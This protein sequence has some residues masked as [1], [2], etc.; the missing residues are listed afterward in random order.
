MDRVKGGHWMST[1]IDKVTRFLEYLLG[2]VL[3]GM[4]LLTVLQVMLRYVF[5]STLLGGYEIIVYLF[6]YSTSLGAALLIGRS[7]HIRITVFIDF[8]PAAA[9]RIA[10]ILVA[11]STLALHVLLF[12]LSFRWISSAGG[13]LSP[14]LRIPQFLVQIAIPLGCGIAIFY[15]IIEILREIFVPREKVV[16]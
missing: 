6:I 1:I 11:L 8:L 10:N 5:N 13:F 9:R 4:F 7:E 2:V 14:I 16:Q 15:L 12:R 3:A